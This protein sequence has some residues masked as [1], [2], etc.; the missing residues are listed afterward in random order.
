[1]ITAAVEVNEAPTDLALLANMVEEGE[2]AG[3]VAGTFQDVVDPDSG[4]PHTF[5]LMENPVAAP[6]YHGLRS[7]SK[8]CNDIKQ[9]MFAKENSMQTFKTNCR[10]N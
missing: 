4:E 9:S 7:P 6:R 8:Y 10:Q 3:T 1:M 2:A 5:T